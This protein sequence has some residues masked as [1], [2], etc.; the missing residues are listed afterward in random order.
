MIPA[1]IYSYGRI[2][3]CTSVYHSSWKRRLKVYLPLMEWRISMLEGGRCGSGSLPN[4]R[5]RRKIYLDLALIFRL[6]RFSLR[7]RFF[8]HFA[9][10]LSY[11]EIELSERLR[12]TYS[13]EK[14]MVSAKPG[15]EVSQLVLPSPLHITCKKKI[16][17]HSELATLIY[18][19]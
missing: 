6:F 5:G 10:I 12:T 1:A 11:R 13:K 19:L 17:Y 4:S 9:R 8:R 7:M 18:F 3:L 15:H 2:R 16:I 14:K